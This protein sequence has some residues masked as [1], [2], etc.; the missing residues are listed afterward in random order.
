MVIRT[1]KM[2]L[3]DRFLTNVRGDILGGLTAGIVA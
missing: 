3:K 1:I 2:N